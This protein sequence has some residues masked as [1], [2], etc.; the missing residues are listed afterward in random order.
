LQSGGYSQSSQELD[1]GANDVQPSYSGDKPFLL[2]GPALPVVSHLDATRRY[3]KLLSFVKLFFSDLECKLR[4]GDRV[5][6]CSIR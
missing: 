4:L 1:L 6:Y 3:T 5:E 2:R